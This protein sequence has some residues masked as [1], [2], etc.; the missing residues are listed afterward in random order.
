MFENKIEQKAYMTIVS[1][2]TKLENHVLSVIANYTILTS[3]W[4]GMCTTN[5]RVFQVVGAH[6]ALVS[7]G[8]GGQRGVKAVQVEQQRA[9]ITLQQGRHATAPERE[10]HTNMQLTDQVKTNV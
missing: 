9:V 10:Q 5:Q 3:E 7:R 2:V 1:S 6:P 4:R 8:Q